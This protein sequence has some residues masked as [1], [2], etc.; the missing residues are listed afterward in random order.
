MWYF[1]AIYFSSYPL[2]F[3]TIPSKSPFLISKI[4]IPVYAASF[5]PKLSTSNFSFILWELYFTNAPLPEIS[6]S[7]ACIAMIPMAFPLSCVSKKIIYF[8]YPMIRIPRILSRK[9]LSYSYLKFRCVRKN[10]DSP[11]EVALPPH[12]SES[13]FL[14]VLYQSLHGVLRPYRGFDNSQATIPSTP[15]LVIGRK[16][17]F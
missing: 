15:F 2:E 8:E 3:K 4:H 11:K 1:D 14:T 5:S 13:K 10:T 12:S 9:S 17:P 7:S 6:K 16:F